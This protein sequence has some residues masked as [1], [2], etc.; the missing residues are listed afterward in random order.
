MA[1]A[2]STGKARLTSLIL[3]GV[4]LARFTYRRKIAAW[5]V[6]NRRSVSA[7]IAIVLATAFVT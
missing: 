2:D 1:C 7:A 3:V 5:H 6:D 4:V